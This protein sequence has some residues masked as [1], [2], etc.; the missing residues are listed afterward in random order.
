MTH[1]DP[2]LS[3]ESKKIVLRYPLVEDIRS[4]CFGP[5]DD[6]NDSVED[7]FSMVY[8]QRDH[9]VLNRLASVILGG[10]HYIASK[11]YDNKRN[12]YYK[13]I[14]HFED[15]NYLSFNYDCL[16]EECLYKRKLWTPEDGFGVVAEVETELWVKQDDLIQESQ[17]LVI[18]P[19]GSIY[20][21]P[22]E[23]DQSKP[24]SSGMQWLTMRDMPLFIF[25]PDCNTS[26][27]GHRYSCPVP[28]H[29]YQ[30]PEERFIPPISNKSGSLEDR[31]YQI[32]MERS[33]DLVNESDVLVSIGYSFADTDTCS[34]KDI[35]SHHFRDEKPLIVI[36][37]GSK[38]IKEMLNKKY[39]PMSPYIVS[40]PMT[41]AQWAERGFP[42]GAWICRPNIRKK[43]SK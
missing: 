5:D 11:I 15:K 13:F 38:D 26:L 22:V 36:S 27:F 41:F 1:T 37:P 28:Q 6:R 14:Q 25:D 33:I 32:L 18:H 21:Y 9:V 31:Y 34:Y 42:L 4:F 12:P 43:S 30:H 39:R 8:I 35:F 23:S 20:L 2:K 40:L 7:L 29:G 19:H 24:D 17:S 3:W 10:D 16:L